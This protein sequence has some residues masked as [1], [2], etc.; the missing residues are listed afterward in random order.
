MTYTSL[1]LQ[2]YKYEHRFSPVKCRVFLK[3]NTYRGARK[4]DLLSFEL[5]IEY[6]TCSSLVQLVF[7]NCLPCLFMLA[8]S[9]VKNSAFKR[10]ILYPTKTELVTFCDRAPHLIF[11]CQTVI[12]YEIVCVFISFY[13]LYVLFRLWFLEYLFMCYF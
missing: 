11:L 3:I 5:R 8:D 4:M 10:Y 9:W 7:S 2:V 12:V 1:K 13:F 6:L